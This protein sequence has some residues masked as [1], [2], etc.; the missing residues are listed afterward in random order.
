MANQAKV[1]EIYAELQLSTAKF[2]AALGEATGEARRFSASMRTQTEEARA[3][4]ALLSEE[5]GVHIPRHLR[6]IAAESQVVSK[7]MSAIFSSVAVIGWISVVVEA[8][9][10]VYEFAQKNEETAK[11]NAES[12]SNAAKDVSGINT[13]LAISNSKID[14]TIA[15]LE[16]KPGSNGIATALLEAADQADKLGKKLD[17]DLKKLSD[18]KV[19]SGLASLFAGGPSDVDKAAAAAA[20]RLQTIISD[21]SAPMQSAA[22]RGDTANYN[23]LRRDQLARIAS[24]PEFNT[25]FGKV[26]EYLRV[27]Q[28]LAGQHN[29]NFNS[30]ANAYNVLSGAVRALNQ[31]QEQELGN[32]KVKGIE[33]GD[34]IADA[35]LKKIEQSM[36]ALG[37][38]PEQR[39]GFLLEQLPSAPNARARQ[40]L[41]E[42]AI[43][44]NVTAKPGEADYT[45]VARITEDR[46][47]QYQKQY[48]DDEEAWKKHV[49]ALQ[50]ELEEMFGDIREKSSADLAAIRVDEARGNI[51][52]HE[53]A[54]ETASVHQE[55]YRAALKALDDEQAKGLIVDKQRA[56]VE[57]EHNAHIAED[58]L[59]TESAWD[60]MM[61]HF[62]KSAEDTS[63]KIASIMEHTLDGINDQIVGAM[64]GDKTNFHKVFEQAERSLAKVTL[65][66]A[67]GTLLGKGK[68][69]K[70]S[71]LNLATHGSSLDVHVTGT[72]VQSPAQSG[73][74]S[75]GTASSLISSIPGVSG[76]MNSLSS[77][78]IGEWLQQNGSKYLPGGMS[79]ISG[80]MQMFQG[81]QHTK[82][83]G[84]GVANA[85]ADANY[86]ENSL[87]RWLSGFG[88]IAKGA[89]SMMFAGAGGA[90]G[91]DGA[92][93]R[94]NLSSREADLFSNIFSMGPGFAV[95]GDVT[96]GGVYPVGELGPEKVYLPGGS[97][98]V[99]NKDLHSSPTVGY[100]DARG[101]DPVQT[102]M[103]VARGM[104][105]AYSSAVRDAQHSVIDRQR[106]TPR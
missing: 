58:T 6:N 33:T 27:N 48:Q 18:V 47:K 37:I 23:Q 65:E 30:A 102:Q 100:I 88:Q 66:W 13:S 22:E 21:Y 94:S 93:M 34:A 14:D 57:A 38:A 41:A 1:A 36:K 19:S 39:A 17:E 80:L 16:R 52:K 83:E 90:D 12:W 85:L 44:E 77:S 68:G 8:G 26:N 101:T 31:Q 79:A 15:K 28:D 91:F 78:K 5:L 35:F 43:D 76:L 105:V 82:G 59:A 45:G 2:K 46:Q 20:Q 7:A 62:R 96:Y 25:Q 87:S 99:P 106:R 67:E 53:A 63:Q 97:H 60:Q 55:Q 75:G 24:D 4:L 9:K 72:D 92:L 54:L 32:Q 56:A 29:Q 74:G 51:S 73:S 11:K 42:K 69:K 84:S 98:V 86:K 10:K 70:I 71:E 61:D 89:G 103:A 40:L 49:K 104:K 95:G 50:I 64:F 3:S 81:P